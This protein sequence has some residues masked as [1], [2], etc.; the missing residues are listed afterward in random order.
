MGEK[1]DAK[2]EVDRIQK[3]IDQILEEMK[4]AQGKFIFLF[5]LN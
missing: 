1:D 2:W 5:Y 3:R 4:L